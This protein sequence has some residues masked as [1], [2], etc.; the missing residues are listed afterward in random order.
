MTFFSC[1]TV[2]TYYFLLNSSGTCRTSYSA[3]YGVH[4]I[5]QPSN[6][7]SRA[8]ITYLCLFPLFSTRRFTAFR[9]DEHFT[10][11]TIRYA[12]G[13]RYSLYR[14]TR[15]YRRNETKFHRCT[16][17]GTTTNA[18]LCWHLKRGEVKGLYYEH[19]KPSQGNKV[20]LYLRV[21]RRYRPLLAFDQFLEQPPPEHLVA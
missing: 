11:P 3:A 5:G 7:G 4:R 15:P 2:G 13:D 6:L 19:K 8:F 20:S 14:S 18:S 10:R 16:R 17:I 1:Q 21:G 9:R 12:F